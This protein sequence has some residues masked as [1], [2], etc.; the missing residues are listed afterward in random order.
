MFFGTPHH[1]SDWSRYADVLLRIPTALFLRPS[2]LL[3]QSLKRDAAVLA[4][5]NSEYKRLL[6]TR[7]HDVVSFYELK[8]IGPLGL[9]RVVQAFWKPILI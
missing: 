7:P 3:L 8:G 4:N 9:V 5:L 2:P 6:D 1:G